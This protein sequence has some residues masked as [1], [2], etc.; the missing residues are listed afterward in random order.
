MKA[1]IASLVLGLA[2]TA[3]A[4]D[5]KAPEAAAPAA[6]AAQ[7]AQTAPVATTTQP[8]TTAHVATPTKKVA[9]MGYKKECQEK[10]GKEASKTEVKKC[11]TEM[12][13]EA[14]ANK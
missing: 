10:L 2:L 7:S 14:K 4:A 1:I 9:K 11:V 6:P 13:K 3:N 12:K 8:V 5:S